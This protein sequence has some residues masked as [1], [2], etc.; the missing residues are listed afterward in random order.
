MPDHEVAN[1]LCT[2]RDECSI[3]VSQMI[4]V[5]GV[6]Q[7]MPRK[8]RFT[9][10]QLVLAIQFAEMSGSQRAEVDGL[11]LGQRFV[12]RC[13]IQAGGNDIFVR[14]DGLL[15]FRMDFFG[16]PRM[17]APEHEHDRGSIDRILNHGLPTLSRRNAIHILENASSNCANQLD[18]RRYQELIMPTVRDENMDVACV[19]SQNPGSGKRRRGVIFRPAVAGPFPHYFTCLW[20]DQ[21]ICGTPLH[22]RPKMIIQSV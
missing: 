8:V 20:T 21:S 3:H 7:P 12:Q 13:V 19:H 2:S 4:R 18:D 1:V 6:E 11:K 10:Q 14:Q 16:T 5:S 22:C 9:R 17:G 15:P